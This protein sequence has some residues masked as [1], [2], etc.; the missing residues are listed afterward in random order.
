MPGERGRSGR[1]G[2]ESS[3]ATWLNSHQQAGSIN[4]VQSFLGIAHKNISRHPRS[5]FCPTRPQKEENLDERRASHKI[6][7][8]GSLGDCT[9]QSPLQ[10]ALDCDVNKNGTIMVLNLTC[11][12]GLLPQSVGPD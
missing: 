5:V 11:W 9:Q 3:R 6:E 10:L 7:G 12:D 2:L 4:D 1:E 8:T